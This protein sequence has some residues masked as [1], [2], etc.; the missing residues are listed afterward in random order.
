MG[1]KGYERMCKKCDKPSNVRPFSI[2]LVNKNDLIGQ[3]KTTNQIVTLIIRSGQRNFV[4]NYFLIL[5]LLMRE[6]R[7]FLS[8]SERDELTN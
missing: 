8:R 7:D 6:K 4:F 1:R 2:N 5:L 3:N